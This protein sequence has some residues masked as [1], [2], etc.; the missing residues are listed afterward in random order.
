T[1]VRGG[2]GVF[3]QQLENGQL[4]QAFRYD[5]VR[6]R[7]IFILNPRFSDP[8]RGN[9]IDSFPASVN[10]LA[11]DLRSPY[12]LRSAIGVEQSLPSGLILTVTYNYARGEHLFRSRDINA[13][14][15]G[16][17]SRPNPELGRVAQ[18]ESSGSST[19]HGLNVGL[20]RSF[21]ARLT[22]FGN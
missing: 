22:L 21:G 15:P 19:Y 1:V 8:L 6:Q 17:F 4:D 7:Q 14:L 20:T 13:P 3:Y 11:P 12:Q 2:A 16:E 18:L 10:K 9:P 5:G